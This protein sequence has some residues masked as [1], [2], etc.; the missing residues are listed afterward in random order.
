[1]TNCDVILV[2]QK[3]EVVMAV[4]KPFARNRKP[5]PGAS[6]STIRVYR[7]GAQTNEDQLVNAKPTVHQ[8]SNRVLI[9]ANIAVDKSAAR[10]SEITV[11]ISSE[12]LVELF[13]GHF[14]LKGSGI[15]K[16]ALLLKKT[17]EENEALRRLISHLVLFINGLHRNRLLKKSFLHLAVSEAEELVDSDSLKRLKQAEKH[18]W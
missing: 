2:Y 14:D 11:H 10:Q 8:L 7:G 6:R 16:V 17:Q 1:M 12:A 4:K 3:K 9:H 13:E 15:G 18:A 5:A